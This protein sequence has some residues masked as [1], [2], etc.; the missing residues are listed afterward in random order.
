MIGKEGRSGARN[1]SKPV[2]LGRLDERDTDQDQETTTQSPVELSLSPAPPATAPATVS[3]AAPVAT[4]VPPGPSPDPLTAQVVHTSPMP[5]SPS[6]PPV[7]TVAV[8]AQLTHPSVSSIPGVRS[9]LHLLLP[10]L[11]GRKTRVPR[12]FRLDADLIEYLE[13]HEMY[14]TALADQRSFV[15][16]LNDWIRQ[17]LVEDTPILI[18]AAEALKE[19]RDQEEEAHSQ[20]VEEV[21][22]PE[23]FVTDTPVVDL[24]TGS[25]TDNGHSAP[26]PTGVVTGAPQKKGPSIWELDKAAKSGRYKGTPSSL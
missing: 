16:K 23:N 14:R 25:G 1:G 26:P 18:R 21:V 8:G 12:G 7:R 22:T 13:L 20:S 4:P 5:P 9:D 24:G 2:G 19:V 6:M 15:E 17:R 10:G 3:P 11:V